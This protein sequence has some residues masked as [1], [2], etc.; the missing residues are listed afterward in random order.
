LPFYLGEIAQIPHIVEY[1]LFQIYEQR[2]FGQGISLVIG[3]LI[4]WE[5][6]GILFQVLLFGL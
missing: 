5:K 4:I 1:Y 2:H 3:R 6:L